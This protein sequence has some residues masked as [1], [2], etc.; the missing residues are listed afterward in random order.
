LPFASAARSN[1]RDLLAPPRE[2]VEEI[3][4]DFESCLVRLHESGAGH[5]VRRWERRDEGLAPGGC[6]EGADGCARR[7]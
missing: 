5:V 3:V 4:E 2:R 7:D 6:E 1:L